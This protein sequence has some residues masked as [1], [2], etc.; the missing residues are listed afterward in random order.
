MCSAGYAT[1]NSCIL[2]LR[3]TPS[4]NGIAAT[5]VNLPT[6]QKTVVSA[7]ELELTRVKVARTGHILYIHNVLNS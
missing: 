1:L 2:S 4:S 3:A 5:K 7:G 6:D